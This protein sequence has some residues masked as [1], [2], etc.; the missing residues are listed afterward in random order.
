ML[1]ELSVCVC[2]SDAIQT[3][4][5][6]HCVEGKS[7]IPTDRCKSVTCRS[8]LGEVSLMVLI[9]SFY[10]QVNGGDFSCSGNC[11]SSYFWIDFLVSWF[12]LQWKF[13]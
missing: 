12:T 9:T 1:I 2:V 13:V 10:L 4:P 3:S 7:A 11:R 5:H 6:S 8:V